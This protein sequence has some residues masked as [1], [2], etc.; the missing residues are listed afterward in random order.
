MKWYKDRAMCRVTFTIQR[1]VSPE[2]VGQ[3][4][5]QIKEVG[6]IQHAVVEQYM[7]DSQRFGGLNDNTKP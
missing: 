4:F 5:D 3:L 2:C 6:D 1:E 7:D